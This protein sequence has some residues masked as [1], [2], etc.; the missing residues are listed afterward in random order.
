MAAFREGWALK[1]PIAVKAHYFRRRGVALAISLC[2]SQDGAAGWL[3]EPSADWLEEPSAKCR[4]CTR[5]LAREASKSNA[6]PPD[7][8]RD[9]H[10]KP[11]TCD[12][13]GR[14]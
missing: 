14:D 8:G 4:R 3:V 2:G 1:S 12:G 5:L 7:P 6:T 13:K 11:R 10:G 9:E